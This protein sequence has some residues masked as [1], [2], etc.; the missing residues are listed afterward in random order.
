MWWDAPRRRSLFR[1]RLVLNPLF[2]DEVFSEPIP[3][4]AAALRELARERSSL[5]Y[6]VY[7]W[8]VHRL[9]YL[10]EPTEIP[11][12]RI[13]AQFGCSHGDPREFHR[14][15]WEKVH[16]VRALYPEAR[17]ER[18][19]IGVVLLPSRSHIPPRPVQ[20]RSR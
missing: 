13:E 8:L 16:R 10:R 11:W 9:G 1:A 20:P 3:M 14:T 4:Q 5:A 19:S 6:D 18:S 17:V 15:F 2:F 12:W 7:C